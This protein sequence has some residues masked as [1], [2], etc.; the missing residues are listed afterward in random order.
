MIFQ[1][2]LKS[3]SFTIGCSLSNPDIREC[4]GQSSLNKDIM[5]CPTFASFV[6]LNDHN[7]MHSQQVS[8]NSSLEE[9]SI[10]EE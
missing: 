4:Q 6:K 5:K 1:E 8:K 7:L 3:E 9:T 10:T 2:V